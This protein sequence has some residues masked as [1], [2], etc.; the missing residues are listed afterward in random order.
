MGPHQ[1]HNPLGNLRD[2]G[3]LHIADVL[4]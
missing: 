2:Q 1:L 3:C 4:I